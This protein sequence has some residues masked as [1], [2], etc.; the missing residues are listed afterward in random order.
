MAKVMLDAAVCNHK[1]NRRSNNEDSFYLSGQ[2]MPLR[3]MDRGGVFTARRK[4]GVQLY[5]VCDG[6]GGT[7]NGELSSFLAV[8]SLSF[9]HEGVGPTV[10]DVQL[11]SLVPHISQAVRDQ[12]VAN[13][14][15]SGSTMTLCVFQDGCMRCMHVGDSRI[16]RVHKGVMEQVTTDHS[17]I[18]R[19]IELGLVTPE[20][21][22][23]HPKR[24]AI[25]QYLGMDTSDA[26]LN[27]SLTEPIECEAG[28]WF[29]L[30]SDGLT[31]MVDDVHIAEVLNHS[32]NA[33]LAVESLTQLALQNGGIDNVTVMAL[34]VIE[35][36]N[37]ETVAID[38]PSRRAPQAAQ[39]KPTALQR[40]LPVVK[41]VAGIGFIVTL[42][43]IIAR[44][45]K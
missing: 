40:V 13:G 2:M 14:G 11:L 8:Q 6:M 12:A 29:L 32:Q 23:T 39:A 16:Y 35:A 24:H 18:Q 19:L 33:K 27:P 41:T 28:D 34:H 42:L 44:N 22:K 31:D 20:E 4:G 30:C 7:D 3:A 36:D 9:F 15:F 1:G 26:Q 17:E 21:A 38:R 10:E 37:T 45:L 25:S 43:E 5:S